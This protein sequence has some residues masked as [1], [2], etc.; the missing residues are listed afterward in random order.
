M[1][2]EIRIVIEKNGTLLLQ[3]S[4]KSGP[5]CLQMSGRR[6]A[7]NMTVSAKDAPPCGGWI[8]SLN[9]HRQIL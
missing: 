8:L 7:P 9:S 4:G 1:A 2:E 3:V 6:S 5:Q